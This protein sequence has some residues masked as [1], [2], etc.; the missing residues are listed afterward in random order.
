MAYLGF[1]L[2]KEKLA[3]SGAKDPSAVAASIGMKKYGKSKFEKSAHAGKS[4]EH[5]KPKKVYG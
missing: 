1:K 2:L 3:K 5:M 4:M